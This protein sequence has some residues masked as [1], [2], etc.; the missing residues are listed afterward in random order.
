MC[1]LSLYMFK[2]RLIHKIWILLNSWFNY[3][4]KYLSSKNINENFHTSFPV[5]DLCS[6][7]KVP[8][9]LCCVNYRHSVGLS[10]FH[11]SHCMVCSVI[12]ST[13]DFT[14]SSPILDSHSAGADPGILVRGGVKVARSTNRQTIY[15]KFIYFI[16]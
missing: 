2:Y 12:H 16:D 3:N 4:W 9:F 11:K 15:F 10:N 1:N 7:R 6:F 13:T 8:I 5:Y 14:P